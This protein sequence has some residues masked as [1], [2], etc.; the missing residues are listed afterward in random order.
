MQPFL[1]AEIVDILFFL[2]ALFLG[3]VEGITEFL[4]ISSTGHL[5]VIGD[6]INFKSDYKVF[7]V[8]IQL[9]AVLAV[10]FEYRLRFKNIITSFGRD[11]Q[12][13]RFVFYLGIAFIPAA[14]VGFLFIHQIKERFFNPISV[15][16]ALIIGGVVILAVERFQKNRTAPVNEIDT[17]TWKNALAVGLS[18]ILA[19]IPGASRSGSTIMGGMLFGLSR[20]AATEFSFFLA[21]P[22]MFAA[23]FYDVYKHYDK[24]NST[25]IPVIAVGFIAA[26]ASGL[27]AIRALLKFLSRNN[28]VPFAWYRIVFGGL[29]LLLWAMGWVSWSA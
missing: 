22:V 20:K 9:G 16:M 14:A 17:M 24:F 26:F 23:T 21:V 3:I 13:N 8:V 2:K 18:Q 5:I 11:A 25:D 7:E 29:I 27:F 28:Y 12:V 4:P 10:V 1:C 19:L 6:L 15:A